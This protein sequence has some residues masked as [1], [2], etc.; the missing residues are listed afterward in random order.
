MSSRY[1]GGAAISF[2]SQRLG[3][4]PN[5]NGSV[6]RAFVSLPLIPR[7]AAVS[8]ERVALK[9]LYQTIS[10]NTR[11]AGGLLLHPRLFPLHHDKRLVIEPL[12]LIR[13]CWHLSCWIVANINQPKAVGYPFS[14]VEMKKCDSRT[15]TSG[16]A[17][18]TT[19]IVAKM[20]LPALLTGIVEEDGFLRCWVDRSQVRAFETVT[21]KAGPRQILERCRSTCFSAITW[22]ASCG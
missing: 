22:S 5:V 18:D 14:I 3:I 15:T 20:P 12:T 13:F 4:A 7:I 1:G 16:N 10:A 11:E 2:P 21:V 19:T 6:V 9:Q 8:R 17:F